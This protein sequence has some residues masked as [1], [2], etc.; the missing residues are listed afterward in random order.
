MKKISLVLVSLMFVFNAQAMVFMSQEWAS[1]FC[2]QW[3]EN[4]TLVSELGGKFVNNDGG[5]GYKMLIM[6]RKDCPASPEVQVTLEPGS[7]A[8]CVAGGLVTDAADFS[9]DYLMQATT[10]DW[11]DMGAGKYGPARAMMTGKLGFKGPMGEASANMGPFEEF[12]LI[13]DSVESN[14]SVCP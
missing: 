11:M 9:Y 6:K 3:N 1:A 13:I 4:S 12:L 8:Y 2:D 5:R 14:T 10:A 7:E